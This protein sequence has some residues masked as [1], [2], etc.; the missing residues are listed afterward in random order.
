MPPHQAA[1]SFPSFPS[2]L[3]VCPAGGLKARTEGNEGNEGSKTQIVPEIS[4]LE[5]QKEFCLT[6]PAGRSL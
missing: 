6:P 3:F 2:V 1:S 5:V 4:D